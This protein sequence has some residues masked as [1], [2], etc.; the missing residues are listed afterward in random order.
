MTSSSGRITSLRLLALAAF[1]CTMLLQVQELSHY[2]QADEGYRHCLSCQV[3][4]SV[5][6]LSQPLVWIVPPSSFTSAVA[7]VLAAHGITL[8]YPQ[9]RGPPLHS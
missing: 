5:A 2:H 7:L 6:A 4:N 1:L 3:G 9:P 8:L